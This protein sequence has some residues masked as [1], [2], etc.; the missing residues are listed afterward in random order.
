MLQV[1]PTR[2]EPPLILAYQR[3]HSVASKIETYCSGLG[4]IAR[5][6]SFVMEAETVKWA[7]VAERAGIKVK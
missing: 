3:D 2:F 1:Q 7:Q 6:Q 4:D 5:C